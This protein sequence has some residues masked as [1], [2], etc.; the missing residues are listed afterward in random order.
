MSRATMA[1][2][3]TVLAAIFTIFGSGTPMA[4]VRTDMISLDKQLAPYLERYKL[5]ALAAAVVKDGQI[6]AAGVAGT[7]R[8]GTAT[9]VTLQDRF[10]LGSDTKGM[11]SLLVAILVE[12]GK[13]R[14]SSTVGEIYP[15]LLDKMSPGVK[16]I[17]L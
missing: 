4:Q 15:E 7:R 3:R 2:R 9:P 16:D 12:E 14:W 6:V 1:A 10:H 17:T 5:P 11:T 8:I 13:L